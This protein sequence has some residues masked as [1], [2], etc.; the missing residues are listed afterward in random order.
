MRKFFML[1]G[2]LLFVRSTPI[3]A[4]EM[5]NDVLCRFSVVSDIHVQAGYEKS[6][7]TFQAALTD[8]TKLGF[9]NTLIING[10]LSNG[11]PSDLQ[12]IRKILKK[13][14]HPRHVYFTIGNHEFFRA[15]RDFQ[16]NWKRAQFPN[17]ESEQQSIQRFLDLTG[18]KKVYY[19]RWIQNY[20]FIFL[21]SEHYRQTN[22][23]I[24]E[25]ADLSA[26]QLNWL[27]EKLDEKK[28]QEGKPV[29]VFLHQPLPYTVSGSAEWGNERSVI[30]HKQLTEILAKHPEVILFSGHTHW[31][32]KLPTTLVQHKFTMVNS[33][34]VL[35]PWSNKNKPVEGT[36][37]EGLCIEI[38]RDKVLIKGRDFAKRKWIAK[39]A[40]TLYS[41]YHLKQTELKGLWSV[42]PM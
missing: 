31:E 2:I 35:D 21:G 30:Q 36:Q 15:W 3:H 39:A 16:G 14:P 13:T 20:H 11:M 37:S 7:R 23:S 41:P 19:D 24:K 8:L 9:S 28:D 10:D 34:S 1:L 38:Y 17:G 25:D 32:L 29:F 40:Y 22:P 33:S 4:Q 12:A 26:D 6:I 18:E 27:R 42:L 5:G